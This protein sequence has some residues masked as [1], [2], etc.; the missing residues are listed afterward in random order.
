MLQP[1]V[2]QDLLRS[3]FQIKDVAG[4]PDAFAVSFEIGHDALVGLIG[5]HH[6]GMDDVL[7]HSLSLF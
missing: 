1:R 2:H 3:A 6:Q 4:D 7:P 5:A